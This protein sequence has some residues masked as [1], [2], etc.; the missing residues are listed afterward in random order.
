MTYIL[1]PMIAVTLVL[2]ANTS[3]AD[4][5]GLDADGEPIPLA[6]YTIK[7]GGIQGDVDPD[8][9]DDWVR[10]NRLIPSAYHPEIV[11]FQPIDSDATGGIDG[12]VAPADDSRETWLLMLDTTGAVEPHEL[13][14]TMVHEYAHLMT[15]RLSQVPDSGYYCDTT[16]SIGEGCPIE[17]SYLDA[18]ADL[19]YSETRNG[20]AE[21][22]YYD[23]DFVTEYA[24]TNVVEDIAESFAEWVVHPER[25][26]GDTLA[27]E[28][29]WFFEDY[30]ELIQLKEEIRENL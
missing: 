2:F 30:P 19:F 10:F 8:Q 16:L 18:F 24:S 1:P 4:G 20:E 22:D 25:W 9:M 6:E 17:G 12:T 26:N 15:L 3:L 5:H 23:E 13:D 27:D 11:L 28:K 29:V 7:D 14:R 21:L